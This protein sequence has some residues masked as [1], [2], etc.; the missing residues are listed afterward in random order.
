MIAVLIQPFLE[1]VVF[2]LGLRRKGI[3]MNLFSEEKWNRY[4]S[5]LTYLSVI[6]FALAHGNNYKFDSYF[7]LLLIPFLTISQ[8]ITGF[9]NTFLRVRFNFRMG[10]LFH[11]F[12]NFSALFVMSFPNTISSKDFNIT[13]ENYQLEVKEK[14]LLTNFSNSTLLYSLNND[15][16]FQLETKGLKTKNILKTLDS[17]ELKYEPVSEYID[18]QFKSEKGIPTDSLLHIL[19]TEGYIEKKAKTN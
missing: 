11:A 4:F 5:K 18:V 12:W 15:T 1:E 14:A 2:R 7:F 3:L 16:I 19:E 9:I 17:T 10:Y 8:F 6:A 13:N